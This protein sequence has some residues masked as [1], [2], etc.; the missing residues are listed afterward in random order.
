MR[1]GLWDKETAGG[2]AGGIRLPGGQWWSCVVTTQAA[3]RAVGIR[4]GLCNECELES[5][6]QLSTARSLASK[7]KPNPQASA[8]ACLDPTGLLSSSS[9]VRGHA[10]AS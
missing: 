5:S 8:A 2:P 10:A 4:T 9:N 7:A 6:L 3:Q 1:W